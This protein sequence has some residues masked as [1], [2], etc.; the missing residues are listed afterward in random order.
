VN[1]KEARS[2]TAM[3]LK[4]SLAPMREPTHRTRKCRQKCLPASAVRH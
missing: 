3:I 2:L 1:R 4:N